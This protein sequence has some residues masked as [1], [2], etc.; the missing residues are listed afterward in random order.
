LTSFCL[1][2]KV[3]IPYCFPVSSEKSIF[4][5]LS[6]HFLAI[7]E[8]VT[9][10]PDAKNEYQGGA[11]H[12]FGSM[13]PG[14]TIYNNK[15][16]RDKQEQL[17]N[18]LSTNHDSNGDYG[19]MVIHQEPQSPITGIYKPV[20]YNSPFGVQTRTIGRNT[21][22]HVSIMHDPIRSQYGGRRGDTYIGGLGAKHDNVL[23][24]ERDIL[25]DVDEELDGHHG[26]N[27]GASAPEC[28]L[29]CGPT[30]FFCSKSCSCIHS[31]LHCDGQIGKD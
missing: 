8:D 5:A 6:F 11:K 14:D 9:E 28:D 10:S 26:I 2:R 22:M 16:H 3:S 23:F 29:K 24:P 4:I 19:I 18:R 1:R 7:C 31:D 13:R 15:I 20:P 27:S 30:E 12:T 21:P 17:T 25:H